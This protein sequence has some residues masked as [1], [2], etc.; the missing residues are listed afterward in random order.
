MEPAGWSAINS[1]NAL[2]TNGMVRKILET[3]RLA[4]ASGVG[5]V[6]GVGAGVGA[7]RRHGFSVVILEK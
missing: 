5:R 7:V 2:K 4:G 6:S 3:Q 1:A